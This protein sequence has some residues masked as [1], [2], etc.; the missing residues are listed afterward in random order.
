MSRVGKIPIPVPSGVTVTSSGDTVTVKGPKGELVRRLTG[1]VT[2]KVEGGQLR[3]SRAGDE[4]RD[5]ALHGMYRALCR[6]M[7]EGV[8]K[9][10][11]KKLEVVG[12]SY[13]AAVEG[14]RLKLNVGFSHPVYLAIPKGLTVVCPAVTQILV[15][16]SDKQAVGEFAARVRRTRPPEPYKGKG[17]RYVGEQ[18]VQK[19]GKS[20]VS[21]GE[22]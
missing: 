9:G 19:A 11:E 3:L 22:K 10:F 7:V 2:A 21:G 20:F 13:Q 6:G 18:I 16:G 5:K 8:S 17:V 14:Q 12:V 4:A 1:G 15:T